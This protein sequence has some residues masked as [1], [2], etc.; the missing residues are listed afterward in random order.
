MHRFRLAL[1][2]LE[3]LLRAKRY[4]VQDGVATG[5]PIVQRAVGTRREMVS[6]EPFRA[7]LVDHIGDLISWPDPPSFDWCRG[8]LAAMFDAEGSRSAGALRIAGTDPGILTRVE[9]AAKRLGYAGMRL[10][11]PGAPLFSAIPRLDAQ[12]GRCPALHAI[13][14]KKCR[15]RAH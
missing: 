9:A 2:D 12:C 1:T 8:F 7:S 14:S 11:F 4:L 3:A 15:G 10:T 13:Y 5:E 6:I